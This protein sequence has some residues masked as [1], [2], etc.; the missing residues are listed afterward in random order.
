[1]SSYEP[2]ALSVGEAVQVESGQH[3]PRAEQPRSRATGRWRARVPRTGCAS[4]LQRTVLAKFKRGLGRLPELFLLWLARVAIAVERIGATI[5]TKGERGLAAGRSRRA[6]HSV[7]PVMH[8]RKV[9][10]RLQSSS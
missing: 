2:V 7:S 4:R 8:I 6:F 1:M 10:V 3:A 5:R 9:K